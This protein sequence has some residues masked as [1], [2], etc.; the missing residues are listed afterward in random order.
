[1]LTSSW[2]TFGLMRLFLKNPG[3]SSLLEFASI[4]NILPVSSAAGWLP[5]RQL[6]LHLAVGL[7]KQLLEVGAL[8]VAEQLPKK[9]VPSVRWSSGC[10][11]A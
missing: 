6:V 4:A 11:S 7:G 1:M 10:P 3:F 8:Q 9:S 2:I 5:T